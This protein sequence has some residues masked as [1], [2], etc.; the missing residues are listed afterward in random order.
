[1]NRR[2]HVEP[3]LIEQCELPPGAASVSISVDRVT[4]PMEEPVPQGRIIGTVRL[5]H[6]YNDIATRRVL[7][8]VDFR[9]VKVVARPVDRAAASNACSCPS[10]H[11]IARDDG[12]TVSCNAD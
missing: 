6:A 3:K 7:E 12:D 1:M 5:T 11:T 4:V 2:D 9:V 8:Y 10:Q